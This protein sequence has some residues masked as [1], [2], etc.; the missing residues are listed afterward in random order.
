MLVAVDHP[1]E[2]S[3]VEFPDSKAV[4]G[5]NKSLAREET[6][7]LVELRAQ[8]IS[9]VITDLGKQSLLVSGSFNT[10]GAFGGVVV[11][12]EVMF[13]DTLVL[14]GLNIYGRLFDAIERGNITIFKPFLH[15]ISDELIDN[16]YLRWDEE[17]RHLTG[18]RL[19]LFLEGSAHATFSD[20]PLIAEAYGSRV[21][22][23]RKG[24]AL[25]GT[26]DGIR[27]LETVVEYIS[28]S[29]RLL[30]QDNNEPPATWRSHHILRGEG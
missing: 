9:F 14:G 24:D 10:T 11:V 7:L 16:P 2:A 5:L 12:V 18:L 3:I 27:E 13:N 1:H 26:V 21:Q 29:A 20:F 4:T 22:H 28:A 30:F 23:S 15:S 17:W 8:D 19:K 6:E 25:L